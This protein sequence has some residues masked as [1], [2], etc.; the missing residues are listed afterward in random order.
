MWGR[1]RN[2]AWRLYYSFIFLFCFLNLSKGL[3]GRKGGDSVLEKKNTDINIILSLACALFHPVRGRP[4][5]S[6][7]NKTPGLV[8]TK[9]S[10][11]VLSLS[12]CRGGTRLDDS[13]APYPI[14][15]STSGQ[16]LRGERES[17][18]VPGRDP[19]PS[20]PL[21]EGSEGG[22]GGCFGEKKK[23]LHSFLKS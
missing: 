17:V 11:V 1:E 8:T 13:R 19:P 20:A 4:I 5:E 3:E 9:T 23:G 7:P 10:D 14:P 2:L 22:G 18:A 16:D 6:R 12:R 15:S 21:G